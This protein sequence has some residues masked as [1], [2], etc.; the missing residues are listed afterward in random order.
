MSSRLPRS[1]YA[2]ISQATRTT[3][4]T[5]GSTSGRRAGG[6]SWAKRSSAIAR[7]LAWKAGTYIWP[8]S[9]SSSNAASCWLRTRSSVRMSLAD[10]GIAI[11]SRFGIKAGRRGAGIGRRLLGGVPRK[12]KIEPI[13]RSLHLELD[14]GGHLRREGHGADRGFEA[15]SR[16]RWA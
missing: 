11:G 13:L 16:P 14:L 12:R 15:R 10:D 4:L 7:S 1:P 5:R 3:C 6:R 2:S 9:P 8:S